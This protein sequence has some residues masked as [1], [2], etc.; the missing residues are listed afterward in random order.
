M[1]IIGAYD[2]GADGVELIVHL[3]EARTVPGP[4]GDDDRR[5][6]PK[7]LWRATVPGREWASD[8]IAALGRVAALAERETRRRNKAPLA[9]LIGTDLGGYLDAAPVA[10]PAQPVDNVD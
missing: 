2:L 8:Q 6:D 9:A 3:D 5:P 4:D 7:W 1:K 10:E